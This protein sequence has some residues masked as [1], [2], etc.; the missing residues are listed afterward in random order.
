MRWLH[1]GIDPTTAGRLLSD[2]WNSS[3]DPMLLAACCLASVGHLDAVQPNRPGGDYTTYRARVLK[4]LSERM[5]VPSTAVSDETVGTLACLLSFELSKGN[6]EA[7]THL[8]GLSGIVNVKGGVNSLGFDGNLTMMVECL[9]L[10]HAALFDTTPLLTNADPGSRAPSPGMD[11]GD[12][13]L[14]DRISP[15]LVAEQ[16][17]LQQGIQTA[18][19][20]KLRE[21]PQLLAS[22]SAA[23]RGSS[24]LP[25]QDFILYK[26]DPSL[27]FRDGLDR[28]GQQSIH[29]INETDDSHQLARAC[30]LTL[31]IFYNL[32]INKVPYRHHSNQRNC[33]WL[34]DAVRNIQ[35]STWQLVP[36][37][38][39]WILLT[40]MVAS[41]SQSDKSVF[42]AH[43]VRAIFQMGLPDWRRA[44]HFVMRFLEMKQGLERPSRRVTPPAE[45]QFASPRLSNSQIFPTWI[46]NGGED[47]Y[48]SAYS[49]AS[50][51][52]D[53][54]S[55]SLAFRSPFLSRA[56]SPLSFANSAATE[57]PSLPYQGTPY[58]DRTVD[59]FLKF[60]SAGS[61]E[62]VFS[63]PS[64][65]E[66]IWQ[67]YDPFVQVNTGLDNMD[68][69]SALWYLR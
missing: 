24:I 3:Q 49:S 39:L 47:Q 15:L 45:N 38:R 43:F 27:L 11:Q 14:F 32:A 35:D 23:L 13:D 41:T 4:E 48:R 44:K 8:R 22:A 20:V 37:F 21:V 57:P 36:Y 56:P 33:Q 10:I 5:R 65:D 55:T 63:V 60:S 52:G 58:D 66:S 6:S 25:T 50:S 68:G 2:A 28:F 54:A 31:V 7:T 46:L 1:P 9:D 62:N 17:D 16:Q 29:G 61:E 40:G 59:P 69:P 34:C 51:A 67:Q 26:D 18:H 64:A 12:A 19:N 30:H 42:K 53:R